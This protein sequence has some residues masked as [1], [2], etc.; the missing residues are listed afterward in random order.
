MESLHIL[1]DFRGN[2]FATTQPRDYYLGTRTKALIAKFENVNGAILLFISTVINKE[3]YRFSYGR[4]ASK[5]TGNIT[6]KLPTVN[7][8]PDWGYM[9]DFIQTLPFSS[10]I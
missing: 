8:Q 2:F 1:G 5:R 6:I 10:Q 9:T 4:V 3:R 7:G